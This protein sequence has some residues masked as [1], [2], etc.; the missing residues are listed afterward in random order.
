MKPLIKTIEWL[1]GG[2]LFV[3]MVLITASAFSRYV[4]NAP[5]L[6]SDDISRLLLLPAIFFGLAAACYHGDH[7]LVDL[8]WDSLG[9]TSKRVVDRFA[10]IM[11]ILIVGVMAYAAVGRVM[12]IRASQVG[13]YEMRIPLW[14]FFA[15]ACVGLILS[16]V[17]LV[18]RLF[19]GSGDALGVDTGSVQETTS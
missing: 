3:V 2:L 17:V 1:G 9:P 11:M 18:W 19:A 8:I 10:T 15:V 16:T 14:P 12:D 7:I 13:T 5:L 4:F 6:D